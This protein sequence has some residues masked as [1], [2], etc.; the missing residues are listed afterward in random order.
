MI[1][2]NNDTPL[3]E[4]HKVFSTR[5]LPHNQTATNWKKDIH[6]K[7]YQ[8]KFSDSTHITLHIDSFLEKEKQLNK[9]DTWNKLDKNIKMEKLRSFAEKF[10]SQQQN[11]PLLDYASLISFLNECLD[12]NKLQKTRDLVYD[13]FSH[14]IISIPSLSYNS[15]TNTFVFKN[16]DTKRVS[17]LK[18]LTPKRN[19]D[20]NKITI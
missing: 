18:S 13:K 12:K 6:N 15:I 2:S 10:I 4:T 17:S 3:L 14:E 11:S 8:N 19:F 5:T 16:I 7:T 20:K 9:V 1:S